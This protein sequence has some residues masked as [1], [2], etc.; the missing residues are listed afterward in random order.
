MLI[1]RYR[2]YCRCRFECEKRNGSRQLAS[3]LINKRSS[4]IG[5]HLNS[6]IASSNNNWRGKCSS[7]PRQ[8]KLVY[9]LAESPPRSRIS[10]P[11]LNH[12]HFFSCSLSLSL[13]FFRLG[14]ISNERLLN[15]ARNLRLVKILGRFFSSEYL[16]IIR[17]LICLIVY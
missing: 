4:L 5:D 11:L 3:Y 13:G 9:L 16:Q 6:Y 2:L 15:G 12:I 14:R 17:F 8:R 7:L 10:A 1:S